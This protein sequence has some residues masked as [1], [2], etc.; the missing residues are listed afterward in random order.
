MKIRAIEVEEGGKVVRYKLVSAVE[1]EWETPGFTYKPE[2]VVVE[3]VKFCAACGH[4][5]DEHLPACVHLTDGCSCE[6]F[7]GERSEQS[8]RSERDAEKS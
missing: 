7:D 6:G 8:K 1:S 3:A 5:E 4:R 2:T